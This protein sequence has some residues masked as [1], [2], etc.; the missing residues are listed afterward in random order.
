[1]RKENPQILILLEGSYKATYAAAD[2]NRAALKPHQFGALRKKA[3]LP[4]PSHF[5]Q[6]RGT[7]AVD[8]RP[9]AHAHQ[10]GSRRL[11]G[12]ARF[13]AALFNGKYLLELR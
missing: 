9:L 13:S 8:V 5:A 12:R 7:S 3:A 10:R 2:Q 1:M 4:S 11:S 6:P